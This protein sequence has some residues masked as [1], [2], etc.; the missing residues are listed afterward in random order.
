MWNNQLNSLSAAEKT[1]TK[2]K[3]ASATY[4]QTQI[5][6]KPLFR[7][8]KN[9]KLPEDILD[10]LTIIVKHLLERNYIL[11]K[12]LFITMTKLLFKT[13]GGG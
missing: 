4:T 11:V 6:L 3:F 7:K 13:K 12:L 1:G 9:K 10:S 8:L 5:Y 2:G